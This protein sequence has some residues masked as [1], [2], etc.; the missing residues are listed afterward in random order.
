MTYLRWVDAHGKE[1]KF[2]LERDE[3][4]IGRR[5]DSDIVFAY[6]FVSRQHAKLI[7]SAAGYSILNLSEAH[8]TYVNGSRIERQQLQSGDRINLGQGRIELL[9][10]DDDW[11]TVT[12]LSSEPGDLERYLKALPPA[13]P[14]GSSEQSDL[15]KISSI[16]DFQYQ[17][18]K[19]F[20]S[21]KAFE[22]IVRSALKI[23]EAQRGC[24]LLKR[25][26]GFE[27]VIALNAAGSQLPLSDFEI[28]Q[29]VAREAVTQG[30]LIYMPEGIGARFAQQGSIL[31]LQLR[32]LACVPLR[33]LSADSNEVRIRGVLYLDSTKNMPISGLGQ[34][35]LKKLALEAG[36][37]FEKIEMIKTLE[38]RKSLKLELDLVQNELLAADALRRA[39][40]QIL[41][42]EYAGS[43]GRFAA[44]LSHE[45]NSPLGALKNTLQTSRRL[46]ERKQTASG[47]KLAELE[48]IDAELSR[49]ALEAVE[50]L[51]QM[52]LRMQRITN[53]DRDEALPTDLNAL[54]HDVTDL[55]KSATK[56]PTA[57][58]FDLETL[59][60]LSIRPQ[61]MSAVFSNLLQN[62]IESSGATGTVK[63]ST[64]RLLGSVEIVFQDG[65]RGISSEELT[66]V[67]DPAFRVREGRVSTGNWGLFSS[68]QIVR[69][70]GGDI[71]I[72]SSPGRGTEV[73][74]VLPIHQ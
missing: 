1:L 14:P 10:S 2:T 55:L 36:N 28:S 5:S 60:A 73:R 4:L 9:Y 59:P 67:F 26:D 18:E 53:L 30:E 45:L 35:I 32:S 3:V 62:A 63:I 29:S 12:I 37:I 52:V 58:E 47:D 57:V 50:R 48:A 21:G 7:K 16:L 64:H 42:S 27:Y 46:A 22:H 41:L 11:S 25:E 40:A 65:G 61:Q 6:P 31:G 49:T 51:N 13:F 70:C 69:E 72:Q 24:I 43:I 23:T 34:K 44:A 33:W 20:S 56:A 38:E 39:E 68:R 15:A 74:I 71:S 19:L 66:H 8:G 54:L 17:W